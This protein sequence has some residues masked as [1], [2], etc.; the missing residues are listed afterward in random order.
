VVVESDAVRAR[1]PSG[2]MAP[3]PAD[4]FAPRNTKAEGVVLY[5]HGGS[6]IV[7]RSPRITS[8]VS[9]FAAA[10][11]ARLCV[12]HYRLSP[13]YP[14]PAAVEDIVAVYHWHRSRW[15][16]RQMFALAESS[17]ASILLAALQKIRDAHEAMPTGVMLLSPWVDLSLQ[18]WSVVHASLAH[19]VPY[20]MD[21]L[22]LMAHLYLQGRSSTDPIASPL[23]GDFSGFPPMLIHASKSDILFDDAVRLAE[24]VGANRRIPPAQLWVDEAPLWERV[25]NVKQRR[26]SIA[27]VATFMRACFSSARSLR[28]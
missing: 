27:R 7:G 12:P 22:A 23:F 21:T 25:H 3:I 15:P 19:T 26:Q 28:N 6:F 4:W 18:S 24:R 10:A 2:E 17:G 11:G 1:A 13:E 20:S 8:L 16:K 14:C 5:V 9:R